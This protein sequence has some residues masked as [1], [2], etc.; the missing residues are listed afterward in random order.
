MRTAGA[1]LEQD[2]TRRN[3]TLRAQSWAAVLEGSNKETTWS[4][5]LEGPGLGGHPDLDLHATDFSLTLFREVLVRLCSLISSDS[6]KEPLRKEDVAEGDIEEALTL[7]A[8]QP[9]DSWH[10]AAW[11]EAYREELAKDIGNW[12]K[13]GPAE[14]LAKMVGGKKPKSKHHHHVTLSKSKDLVRAKGWEDAT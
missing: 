4:I 3:R 2:G 9:Q 7:N 13:I 1:R 6:E 11:T 12:V 14:E 8:N 10:R 5:S